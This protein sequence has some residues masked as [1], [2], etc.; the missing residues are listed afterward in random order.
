MRRVAQSNRVELTVNSDGNAMIAQF[1]GEPLI[2]PPG[3]KI[4]L[5][6]KKFGGRMVSLRS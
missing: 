5:R 4:D 3:S 2:L 6:L 1:D